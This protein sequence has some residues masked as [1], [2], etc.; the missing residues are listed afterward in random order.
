M[1][2]KS[3]LVFLT[4]ALLFTFVFLSIGCKGKAVDSEDITAG[5]EASDAEIIKDDGDLQEKEISTAEKDKEEGAVEEET[6]QD[7]EDEESVGEEEDVGEGSDIAE[8]N[9]EEI[10]VEIQQIIDDAED[11]YDTGEYALAEKEYRKA[12]IEIQDS[13]ISQELKDMLLE[14]ID[15]K[16]DECRDIIETARMHYANSMRLQYEK[17]FE[18][19]L[20]ELESALAIYPKYQEAIDAYE[21]L[22]AMMGLS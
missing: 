12:Q 14:E 9:I 7:P 11:Y 21:T 5:E 19:A 8:E 3:L 2:N 13:D 17:R 6:A 10:P 4:L 16:Y 18:E 15:V 20:T 1:R 22:K